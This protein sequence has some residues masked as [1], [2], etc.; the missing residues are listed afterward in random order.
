MMTYAYPVMQAQHIWILVAGIAFVALLF[1]LV[2]V[3]AIFQK[4]NIRASGWHGA[5]G[6][7]LEA[8]KRGNARTEK[9]R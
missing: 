9:P 2:I 7:S 6:F 4:Y 5:S 1:F 8:Q 3:I